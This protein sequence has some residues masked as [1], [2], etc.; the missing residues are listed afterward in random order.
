M[1]AKPSSLPHFPAQ[2]GFRE[3]SQVVVVVVVV[4]AVV[5]VVVEV[6]VVVVVVGASVA[7]VVVVVATVVVAHM[8]VTPSQRGRLV[9]LQ[10]LCPQSH[11]SPASSS[12]FLQ[13][14]LREGP[15]STQSPAKAGSSP[16]G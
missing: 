1:S 12:P 4:V 8:Q 11:S 9:P 7:A 14:G 6:V 3:K 2:L 10:S 15:V 13:M 5:V 16:V